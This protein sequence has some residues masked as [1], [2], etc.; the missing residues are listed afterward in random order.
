MADDVS[1]TAMEWTP[2]ERERLERLLARLVAS[3]DA[4]EQCIELIDRLA[5]SGLLAGINA[6]LEEFDETFS[7]I[8][9]PELM[10]MV[11]NAM[12]LLGLLSQL[13]Y[14][15]FFDLA[16]RAPAVMNEA[17][18]R[19]KRRADRLSVREALDLLR[20]PEVAAALELLVAVLRAQ[21]GVT[22]DSVAPLPRTP[23]H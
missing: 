20:S 11:A 7:A 4:L 21:R 17:Y 16:M 14:E 15:P 13:R 19:F 6:V 1:L 3:V 22:G 10:G 9:R 12:M 2:D 23:G 5:S 18:P 8:N